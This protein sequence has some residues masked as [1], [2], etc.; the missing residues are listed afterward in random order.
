MPVRCLI[1]IFSFIVSLVFQVRLRWWERVSQLLLEVCGTAMS[2][3]W[4]IS[5]GRANHTGHT[6]RECRGTIFTNE[7]IYV[8]DGRKIR[9]FYHRKCYSGD[10]DPR[11]QASSSFTDKSLRIR[12]SAPEHKG[13][14]KWWT[15]EFG[16]RGHVV[17]PPTLRNLASPLPSQALRR[18]TSVIQSGSSS[19]RVG[20]MASNNSFKTVL[21][22]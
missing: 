2:E 18:T 1:P 11:T 21:P 7:P 10:A 16:Y 22:P 15:N 14:G 19:S 5:R 17:A 6:C 13:R 20:A 4:T 3:Y 12:E 9:L 8:R